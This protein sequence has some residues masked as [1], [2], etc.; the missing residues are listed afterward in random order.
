[1]PRDVA[2]GVEH[3]VPPAALERREPAV[4]VAVQLL[5]LRKESGV[6]LAAVESGHLVPAGERGLDQRVA[7]ELRA[8]DQEQLQASGLTTSPHTKTDSFAVAFVLGF[9]S[10]AT[11][12]T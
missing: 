1:M 7:E 10:H 4:A 11:F 9:A 3:G 2:G 12:Q 8:A 6:R 5:D